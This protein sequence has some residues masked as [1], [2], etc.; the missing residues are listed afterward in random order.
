MALD[1]TG[2]KI[3]RL[4]ALKLT[5]KRGK[6]AWEVV[7]ECGTRMV[8]VTEHFL[9]GKTKSCGCYAR[10]I[11]PM[12][13]S[14]NRTTHGFART[15]IYNAWCAMMRRCYN[16]SSNRYR[17]Y[18]GRGITVCARWH[19]VVNFVNDMSPRPDGY[20]LDRINNDGNYEPSN[21]RWA[22]RQQ[23]IYNRQ[24]TRRVAYRGEKR[25]MRELS[26]LCG[27][28]PSILASRIFYNNWTV[29]RAMS[30]PPR[31]TRRKSNRGESKCHS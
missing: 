29:E 19:N 4:T 5:R 23:Q 20:S 17:H 2:R 8:M 31:K 30:T 24:V 3:H 25:T 27:L 15:P 21:C 14:Q 11:A 12:R 7:C 1:L 26:Q 22:T 10:E 13:S 16:K 18:G 9:R 6:R 28:R